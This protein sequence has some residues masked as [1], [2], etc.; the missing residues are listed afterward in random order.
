[1]HAKRLPGFMSTKASILVTYQDLA[2]R[3]WL[4]GVYV[5]QTTPPTFLIRNNL[6]DLVH[7]LKPTGVCG[8]SEYTTSRDCHVYYQT[9]SRPYRP[10][11]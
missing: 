2:N 6:Y 3:A 7:L 11:C 9:P 8:S 4:L 1:M 10:P 5:V